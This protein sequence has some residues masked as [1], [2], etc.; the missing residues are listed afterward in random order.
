MDPYVVSWA[1]APV[2]WWV[3]LAV[4]RR[5]LPA[6]VGPVIAGWWSPAVGWRWLRRRGLHAIPTAVIVVNWYLVLWFFTCLFL[7]VVSGEIWPWLF[8]D[9]L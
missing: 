1:V 2:V 8:T 4:V 3:V 7:L 9:E 5:V 6:H